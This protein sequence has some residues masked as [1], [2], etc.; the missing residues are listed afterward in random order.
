[1]DHDEKWELALKQSG[2]DPRLL[3]TTVGHA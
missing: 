3:S 2:I 1:V